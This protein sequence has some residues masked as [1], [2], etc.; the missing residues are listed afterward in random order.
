MKKTFAPS[1][2]FLTLAIL[3]SG[4]HDWSP[5]PTAPTT[6]WRSTNFNISGLVRDTVQRPVND[7]TI[8]IVD[9]SLAGRRT[10]TNVEGRFDFAVSIAE[11]VSIH[12]TKDGFEPVTIPGREDQVVI[13]TALALVQIEGLYAATFTAADGCDQLQPEL[14]KRTYTANFNLAPRYRARF[15]SELSGADFYPGYSTLFGNIGNDMILFYVFSL[16]AFNWW[17][18]DEPILEQLPAGAYLSLSGTA[19]ALVERPDAL[20]SATFA[21]SFAYCATAERAAV[22]FPPSCS[23][24]LI[25]CRSEHHRLTLSRR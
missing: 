19:T 11:N 8:E 5:L 14:R 9:G 21:G 4:C 23:V 10:T 12:I 15:T 1:S 3:A 17:L 7:A 22:P 13:L 18:D 2:L 25:E 20:I 24:A 6:G 16:D